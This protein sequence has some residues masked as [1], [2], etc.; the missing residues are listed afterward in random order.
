MERVQRTPGLYVGKTLHHWGT[1]RRLHRICDLHG[2]ARSTHSWITSFPQPSC[3]PRN[4][5]YAFQE[6]F[7][8]RKSR[9]YLSIPDMDTL[10]KGSTGQIFPIRA[11]RHTVDGL[12]ML[13]QCVDA[14][15]SL[16]IPQS[17]RRIKWSTRKTAGNTTTEMGWLSRSLWCISCELPISNI[18]NILEFASREHS[19]E[20]FLSREKWSCRQTEPRTLYKPDR[21]FPT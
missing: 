21:Y 17:N 9:Y 15:A 18:W 5:K 12:L 20:P 7:G 16:H 11:E 14:N 13:G 6:G 10:V 3:Q 1:Q 8:H 4:W 2:K 19:S